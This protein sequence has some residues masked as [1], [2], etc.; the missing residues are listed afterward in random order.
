M[1]KIEIEIVDH[2]AIATLD[3]PPVNALSPEWRL[4]EVFD[5]LSDNDEVRVIVLTGS[6]DR[7]FCAGADIK[8]MQ[9]PA[10]RTRA[11]R[12][13]A[14]EGREAFNAIYEC[15]QPVIAAVN[16]P[17]L[18]AGLAIAASCDFVIASE[19]ATFGLPEIDLGILGGARHAMRMFPHTVA[20]R[21]QFTAERIG[22]EEAWRLGAVQRVVPHELLMEEAMRDA[23]VIASK[24]PLGVRVAKESLNVLEELDLRNGYRHEQGESTRIRQSPDYDE[25]RAAFAE[26][27][28]PSFSV[29]R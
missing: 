17:A 19:R 18:G 8:A 1:P 10:A 5:E 27:R 14:R 21:M 25:T 9:R 22:A 6:G 3:N 12:T 2:I 13:G 26:K 24:I 4:A 15:A 7:A 20:R 29:M 23:R 11:A 16:G 28:P